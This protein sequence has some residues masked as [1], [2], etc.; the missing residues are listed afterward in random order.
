[1]MG[2]LV[3]VAIAIVGMV[4]LAIGVYI[5]LESV[6]GRN[7]WFAG[8][9]LSASVHCLG[10]ALELAS[11]TV[12][13]TMVFI[14]LEYVGIVL[15][16]FFGLLAAREFTG[17]EI[18]F[19]RRRDRWL[20]GGLLAISLLTLALLYTND[21]H[22]QYYADL[23][24]T[25]VAGLNIVK[26][27]P[28][29]WYKVFLGSALLSSVAV[30]VTVGVSWWRA[31]A[32][33]RPQYR[34]CML[35][36]MMPLVSYGAYALGW[37][38]YGMDPAPVYMLF[39]ILVLVYGLRSNEL[40]NIVPLVRRI[41]VD[42]MSD[43]LVILN[44]SNR[45]VDYNRSLRQLLTDCGGDCRGRR[46]CLKC[47]R[48]TPQVVQLV[49]EGSEGSVEVHLKD[50]TDRVFRVTVRAV[51]GRC[52]GAAAKYLIMTDITNEMKLLQSMRNL[53][54]ADALT[55]IANRRTLHSKMA[56]LGGPQ[57]KGAST[58]VLMIDIDNFKSVNDAYGHHVGDI[59]LQ[60]VASVLKSNIRSEDTLVRY[61]GEEFLV[62]AP[63]MSLTDGLS[64]A[65]RLRS[66]LDQ[67]D[68]ARDGH[69]VHVT[70][71]IGVA[72]GE[73]GPGCNAETSCEDAD[74]AL[75]RPSGRGR[76]GWCRSCTARRNR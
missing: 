47:S 10:Y 61:G 43:I 19:D 55:N 66:R 29:P 14:K 64:L 68:V 42:T 48:T 46:R 32:D 26:I 15:Y 8:F 67:L 63:G 12:D 1:M 39:A 75:T 9:V 35:G 17:N 40:L 6:R 33:L 28:G 54:C 37:T 58:C 57:A 69:K 74:V 31:P 3:I 16:P 20:A 73:V 44:N 25:R 62:L 18:R 41:M 72:S 70:V 49:S 23:E 65:E 71:S 53:A 4:L 13:M 59:V 38:P 11:S 5:L 76:T 24:L 60:E 22:H 50:G 36:V 52:G 7:R 56:D 30:V 21:L 51:R 45:I 27:I 34:L 2:Y